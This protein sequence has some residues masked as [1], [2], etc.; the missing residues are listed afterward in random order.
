MDSM[1]EAELF[2][3]NVFQSR[4]RTSNES[5]KEDFQSMDLDSTPMKPIAE[6]QNMVSAR[7]IKVSS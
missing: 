7:I 5:V 6:F 2:T 3:V 4:D 1:D